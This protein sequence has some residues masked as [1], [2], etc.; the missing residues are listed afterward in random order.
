MLFFVLSLS[1]STAFEEVME[2]FF[3]T[4]YQKYIKIAE[5]KAPLLDGQFMRVRIFHIYS[6][7]FNNIQ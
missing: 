7:T 6:A 1:H 2:E 4:N 5:E 3:I